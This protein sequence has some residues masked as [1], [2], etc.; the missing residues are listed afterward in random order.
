MARL[1]IDIDEDVVDELKSRYPEKV[2]RFNSI[3]FEDAV[4][5]ALK[6]GFREIEEL[7]SHAST[8]ED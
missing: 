4:R 7:V 6:N 1:S 2:R 5:F 3:M 8:S